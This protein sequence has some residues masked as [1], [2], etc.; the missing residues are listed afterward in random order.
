MTHEHLPKQARHKEMVTRARASALHRADS[1]ATE[2]ASA[3]ASPAN[4]SELCRESAGRASFRD[5]DRRTYEWPRG[6]SDSRACRRAGSS[7]H[8]L[9]VA[10]LPGLQSNNS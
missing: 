4:I 10:A 2:D 1:A 8:G 3:P 6:C 7:R 9:A 5:A